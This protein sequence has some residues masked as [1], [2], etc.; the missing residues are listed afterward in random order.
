LNIQD[1]DFESALGAEIKSKQ[2]YVLQQLVEKLSPEATEEDNL[3]GST[4]LTDMLDT[5]EF[6][7]VVCQRK[8]IQRLI[9]LSFTD[10]ENPSTSS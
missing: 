9:D 2:H 7:N 1:H 4:I 3:N 5:K 8:H 10:S 6:Y